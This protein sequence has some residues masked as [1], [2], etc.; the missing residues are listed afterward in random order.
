MKYEIV[1]DF[2]SRIRVRCGKYAFTE[3]EGYGLENSLLKFDFVKDITS[4]YRNGSLLI[5]YTNTKRNHILDFINKIRIEDLKELEPNEKQSLK[6]IDTNFQLKLTKMIL[7]RIFIKLFVPFP[8][9]IIKVLHDSLPFIKEGMR[10]LWN[11]RMD[12][13]LLDSVAI[14]G[15]ILM[16]SFNSAGSVIFWVS[17]ADLLEDYTVKR[18]KNTLKNSLAINVDT[19][20]L[21][22]EEDNI[23]S[24]EPELIL[25]ENNSDEKKISEINVP[26]S[27]ISKGDKIRIRTGGVIPVDG[28]ITHGDA[29]INESSMTGE[30]LSVHKASG[31]TVHAGTVVEEGS[32]IVEV[33]AVDKET[34]INK[35]IEL[36]E[37]S[38]NL[39]AEI[40]SKAENLADS[41]VPFSLFA[42]F[43]TYVLTRNS[44]KAL[45]V[46]MVDYSCAIKLAT[47][48]SVISAMEEASNHKIMIKGGKYLENFTQAKTIVFDKTGTLTKACPKVAKIIPCGKL[49]REEVLRNSACLEEHFAHSVARAIVKQAELENLKHE[50]YHAEV[51]YIVAHG[52]STKLDN[53]KTLIGSAHF[54]FEDEK[55]T[56]SKKQQKLI[57][58]SI[59]EY[60]TIFFAMDGKLEGIICIEDP[61]R[62][63]AKEVIYELKKL[64]IENFIMLT[65]DSE[66]A[67][68]HVSNELGITEYKSQVLPEDKAAIVEDLR[69]KFGKV[70]MVGDGINDSPALSAADVSVAMMDSSDIAR[71]VAD[72][73][74]LSD[75]LYELLTLRIL[76]S[77]MLNKINDNYHGIVAIN[78]SLIV[79]GVLGIISPSISSLAHNLS[80]VAIGALS[81]R[82]CLDD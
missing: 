12:V 77:R 29:M 20:W 82:N 48:I 70:I 46:L 80:T 23:S 18:T 13:S 2:P 41:I 25:T 56:V 22:V 33:E 63:E 11:F 4:S 43:A 44:T 62:S 49:S 36:I 74:L 35:I 38:E 67:A 8:I 47:P 7:K 39:K 30:P 6:K 10:S 58:E 73:S 31:K 68:R 52:I 60:S 5:E 16:K 59:D 75:D 81:T 1:H 69:D 54:I 14:L 76:S 51:E 78:T 72:I 55:V 32:I 24:N 79:L 17:L 53:K 19:V 15:S 28:I 71:E 40:Q 45:S 66:N 65:G 34:R 9:E 3:K 64:G 21:V 61:I 42:T 26:L 50:E 37:N 27:D 57:D